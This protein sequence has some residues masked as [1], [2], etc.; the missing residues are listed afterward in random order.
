MYELHPDPTMGL[1]L[2]TISDMLG[3]REVLAAFPLTDDERSRAYIAWRESQ[4]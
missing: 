3:E 1:E 4:Q 2:I